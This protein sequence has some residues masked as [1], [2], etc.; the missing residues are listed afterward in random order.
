MRVRARLGDGISEIALERFDPHGFSPLCNARLIIYP[1]A[2]NYVYYDLQFCAKRRFILFKR[3]TSLSCLL[4]LSERLFADSERKM[5][6]L[7]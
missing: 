1:A 7:S 2:N 6:R 5:Y 3:F 4:P